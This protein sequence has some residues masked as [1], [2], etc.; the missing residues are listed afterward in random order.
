M[1]T[2]EGVTKKNVSKQNVEGKILI[3]QLSNVNNDLMH[4]IKISK[5]NV[6]MAL[7]QLLF[8]FIFSRENDIR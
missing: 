4:I 8:E 3:T 2:A 5:D 7:Q 1:A 6:C